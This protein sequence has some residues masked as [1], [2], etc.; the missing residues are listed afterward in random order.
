M[1]LEEIEA[2][3]MNR[4]MIHVDFMIGTSDLNIIGV[5]NQGKEIPIFKDGNW[6]I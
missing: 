2:F 5:D 6:V 3:P 4:S 1:T